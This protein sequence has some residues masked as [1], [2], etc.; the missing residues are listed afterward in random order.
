MRQK[1]CNGAVVAVTEVVMVVVVVVQ[2]GWGGGLHHCLVRRAACFRRLEPR[3]QRR[4]LNM[5]MAFRH[6]LAKALRMFAS[7]L[8]EA[9]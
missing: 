5:K 4:R 6:H 1:Y 9:V 8:A 3:V 7:A 2:R